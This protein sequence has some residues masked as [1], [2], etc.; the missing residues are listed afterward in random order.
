VNRDPLH[1]L[2]DKFWISIVRSKSNKLFCLALCAL[3]FALCSSAQAQQPGKLY[4]IGYLTMRSD[5]SERHRV[6]AFQE[7]L[8]ELGYTEG[9]NI[10]IELRRAAPGQRERL[11]ELAAELV[12]LKV[13][14]IVVSGGGLVQVAKET[15][16]TIPI[17]FTVHADPVG[18]GVVASLARPGGQVT[19]LSDLHSV[20]VGK[21][22]E[23]LKEVVPSASRIAVL[24]NVA[25]LTHSHQLKDIE[26]VTPAFNMTVLSLPV[27]GPDDIDRAFTAMRKA[28]AGG[29]LVLGDPLLANHRRQIVNLAAKGRLPSIFTTRESVEAGGLMSYGANLSELWRRAATYVDRIFKGAKPADLPVEQPTKFELVINVKTAK[30][31]GLTIPPNVL[32]R[33]DKV[34][35]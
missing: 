25:W 9:K 4:R 23:L 34:V 30:Q 32:A 21:R 33:A 14:V 8:R 19:G 22:I 31:I 18:D 16:T 5:E 6:A 15:T 10:V 3:L 12:R 17:V 11:R 27:T 24:S 2:R 26:A 20:L 35:K 1:W 7:G 29:L 28:R 13:D